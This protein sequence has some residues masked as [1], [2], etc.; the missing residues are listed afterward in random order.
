MLLPTALPTVVSF[1]SLQSLGKVPVMLNYTHGGAQMINCCETAGLSV[2]LTSRRFIKLAKLESV[3]SQ[4]VNAGYIL[5]Y[6]E[7]LASTLSSAHKALGTLAALFPET[8]MKLLHN[9]TRPDDTAVLL[10]TSGSE[11]HPKGVALSHDNLHANISQLTSVVDLNHHD[12]VFNTLPLFHSFGLMGA[13]LLPVLT[14]VKMF[15]YPNPLQYRIITELI[16]DTN[17]TILFG[18]DYTLS[19][20]ANHASSYDFYS[21]RYVFAGAEKLKPQTFSLWSEK[22]G[23]RLFEAYGLT[24]ASPGLC[25]NSAMHCKRG[26]V[27]RFLPKITYKL[28]AVDGLEQGGRLS[29]RG[30]NIMKGYILHSQPQKIVPPVDGWHDTGDIVHIDHDGY[31]TI[32]DRAKRFAKIAGEMVSLAAVEKAVAH[33][34]P[35]HSHA[36]VSIPCTKKGEQLVLYTEH[37]AL[38]KTQLIHALKQSSTPDLWLPK[39]IIAGEIPRLPTGKVDYKKLQLL[40]KTTT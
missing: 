3:E 16:Y 14:G 9:D 21:L 31:V 25:A 37:T 8:A 40:A 35:E 13:F 12:L 23:I 22:F 27:G 33:A 29:V 32:L 15:L 7:D 34:F 28:S 10:F 1:F 24:E 4:L 30:P 5:I 6:L 11:G 38:E 36:V 2:I 39:Q 18:T 26:T 20:Y 19:L 17:A